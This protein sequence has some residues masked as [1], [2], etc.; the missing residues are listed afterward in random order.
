M[1]PI[2]DHNRTH[3]TPY[4]TIGLIA[5]NVIAFIF[6]FPYLNSTVE[7]WIA[8]ADRWTIIP[9]QLVAN[10]VAEFFTVFTAMFLHGGI[11]HL[12]GNML[13]LW[14][15]GDN[16]ENR[17]GPVRFL[18]F[19]LVCGIAATVAQVYIDP[20]STIPNVGASGAIA[21]V[22]GGYFLLFPMAS[23]STLVPILLFRTIQLPAIIVLGFWFLLQFWS[24]WQALGVSSEGGGVAFWAHIGGFVA[25]VLLVK[26][27]GN[28]EELNA[29]QTDYF[30]EY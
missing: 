2:R 27:F 22:L 18:I 28:T 14:I 23:V 4:V 8:F 15:F 30:R 5:L 10:P 6:E 20:T 21:G 26:L 3:R 11:A 7:R 25:G 29:A 13:Y 16:I 1:I 12:G 17:L 9:A 19:Y 24:G